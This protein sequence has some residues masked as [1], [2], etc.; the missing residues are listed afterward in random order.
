MDLL[1]VTYKRAFK[2][3]VDPRT[4]FQTEEFINDVLE[5]EPEQC[6]LWY[7]IG[8]INWF[9]KEDRILGKS[10]FER[11][12]ECGTASDYADQKRKVNEY[13]RQSKSSIQSTNG[14]IK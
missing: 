8:M 7:C 5:L 4:L 3:D 14:N 2:Y 6:Q 9:A 12:L 10:A 1:L 13:L 11:F